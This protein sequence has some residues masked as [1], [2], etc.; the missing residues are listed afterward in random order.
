MSLN[1][2]ILIA[3]LIDIITGKII[4]AGTGGVAAKIVAR[5]QELIAVNTA[6]NEINSGS[7]AG[8]PA[9]QAAFNTT[10]LSP[11]EALALQSLFAS[12]STQISLL[13]TI[14]GSTLLGQANTVILDSV[15]ATATTTAQAYVTK[16][17][18]PAAAQ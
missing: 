17:G 8:L 12:L 14:A 3:P 16:Y 4:E 7:T 11:G 6:L 18:T 1:A 2:S 10:A 5:A 15:L 13:T 9:L